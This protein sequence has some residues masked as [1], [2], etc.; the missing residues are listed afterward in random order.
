MR[1]WIP[2][3]WVHPNGYLRRMPNPGDVLG[4]YR[5]AKGSAGWE[6]LSCGKM[7]TWIIGN[8]RHRDTY[9]SLYVCEQC[10]ETLMI[11]S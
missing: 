3:D 5:Y 6:H 11:E 2:K 9:W 4:S 7:M 1:Y 10:N 8:I